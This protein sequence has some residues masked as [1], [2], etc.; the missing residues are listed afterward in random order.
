MPYSD[1]DLPEVVPIF[2]N[3]FGAPEGGCV[4]QMMPG[5]WKVVEH[6]PISNNTSALIQS[7]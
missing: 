7:D 4:Q 2:L 6:L 5:T 3:T 1:I